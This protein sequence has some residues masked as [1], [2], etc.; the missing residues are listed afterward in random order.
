MSTLAGE[1]WQAIYLDGITSTPQRV[2]LT[3]DE[4]DVLHVHSASERLSF[5]LRAVKI[6]PPLGSTPRLLTLPGGG[7]CELLDQGAVQALERRRG[8]GEP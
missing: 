7:R 1:P 5:P 6:G 4:Q 3:L 8:G 2:A